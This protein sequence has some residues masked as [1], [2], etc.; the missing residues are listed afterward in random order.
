MS[1]VFSLDA[2]RAEAERR[3]APTKFEVGDTVITLPSVLRIGEKSREKVFAAVDEITDFQAQED[4][5][6]AEVAA[7]VVEVAGRILTEVADRPKKLVA[8]LEHDDIEVQAHLYMSV[9][10]KWTGE[11]Q[12]G[13]SRVLAELIDK[14]GGAILSDLL[15]EYGFDLLEVFAEEESVS[16]RYVL[17]LI[18][19]LPATS[20]FYASRRGGAHYRGWDE[21]RYLLAALVNSQRMA[22][23][24]FQ[25]ANRD[26]KK[27]SVPP[28][29]EPIPLPD[30][31]DEK[32]KKPAHKPGSFAAMAASMILAARRKKEMTYG[33]GGTGNSP[34]QAGHIEVPPGVAISAPG[35]PGSGQ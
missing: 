5:D 23:Y 33:R 35:Y 19:N 24:M 3:F 8:A 22:N 12:L 25:L 30:D 14:H 13:G 4:Q 6:D 26:P 27:S 1:N 17:N 2:I 10:T 28:V 9:L 7:K 18:I 29:P 16:P 20:A 21:E 15:H 34:G 11:V 31:K 32:K